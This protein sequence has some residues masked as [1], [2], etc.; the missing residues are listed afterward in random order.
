MIHAEKKEWRKAFHEELDNFKQLNVYEILI[1]HKI[2]I[3]N[4]P[5]GN[6]EKSKIKMEK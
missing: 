2:E 5:Y 3:A 1:H 4:K 6:F